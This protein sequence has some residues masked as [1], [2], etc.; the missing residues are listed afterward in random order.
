MYQCKICHYH[1][2]AGELH[3]GVCDDCVEEAM[4][5]ERRR[6]ELIMM[7]RRYLSEQADGQMVMVI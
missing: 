3:G 5:K 4:K 6:E 7:R 2:D 1:F